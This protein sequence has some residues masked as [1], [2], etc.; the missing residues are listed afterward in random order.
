MDPVT[1]GMAKA[2]TKRA[3]DPLTNGLVVTD[4]MNSWWCLPR[5]HYNAIRQRLYV[6]GV[7][8]GGTQKIVEYDLRNRS[9]R[10]FWLPISSRRTPDDHNVPAFCIE[11]DRPPIVAYDHHSEDKIV[12][13]RRGITPH[14]LGTLLPEQTI[15]VSVTVTDSTGV[16]YVQI[17]EKPGDAN[18]FAIM[19]RVDSPTAI[20][21]YVIRTA[22]GGATWS[23]PWRLHGKSYQTWRRNGNV[24]Q[25]WVS[26]NPQ[27]NVG[28][29]AFRINLSTGVMTNH[30]GTVV[31]GNFWTDTTIVTQGNMTF[32]ASKTLPE[33]VRLFDI[34]QDGTTA[35]VGPFNHNTLTSMTYSTL[36]RPSSAVYTPLI[37]AGVPFGYNASF[38][39]GGM[40]FGLTD[41]DV[42]LIRENAGKWTVE[43]WRRTSG[44]WALDRV[45]YTAP[46]GAKLGRPQFPYK[47]DGSWIT[48]GQYWQ[49][50]AANFTDYYAEQIVLPV[51]A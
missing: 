17:V 5:C 36:A 37:G 13:I 7:T 33:S 10:E 51:A 14:D 27:N 38:Y 9:T 23:A 32:I 49:Y 24:L 28:L 31:G 3:V 22:D 21:W 50:A 16:S 12:R 2:A 40:C 39:V 45:L 8:R 34:S 1:L 25:M 19:V 46:A 11:D 48:F 20:G 18:G 4:L 29:Y 43:K 26:D 41:S 44:T 30:A 6:G 35:L 15:D 47:G 42:Y